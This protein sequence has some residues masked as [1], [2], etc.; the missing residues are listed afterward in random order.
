MS[1]NGAR[2]PHTRPKSSD[3]L[4]A[5]IFTPLSS[6]SST[7]TDTGFESE[8]STKP[9]AGT[10]SDTIP[11]WSRAMADDDAPSIVTARQACK[12]TLSNIFFIVIMID[13]FGLYKIT[14]ILY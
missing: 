7:Q 6:L 10:L 11:R 13:G 8:M 3:R 2:V 4:D 9:S 5:A 14:I 1:D 12:N